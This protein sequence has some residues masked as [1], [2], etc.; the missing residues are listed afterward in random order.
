MSLS[1][2]ACN[3]DSRSYPQKLFRVVRQKKQNSVLRKCNNVSYAF[4]SEFSKQE[5]LKRYEIAEN[6]RFFLTNLV[7]FDKDRFRVPCENNDT[8]LFIGGLIEIKGIRLFCEAVTKAQVKAVV[9]GQ[10][11]LKEELEQKYPN[12]EFVGWKNKAE[13]LPYLKKGR[14]LIFPSICYE[15]MGLTPL[16]VMAYGMPVICSNL[17][18]ASDYVSAD[19]LYDGTDVS[20]LTEKIQ[21]VQAMDIKPVSEEIFCSFEQEKYS[22]E[23]YIQNAINIYEELL[24]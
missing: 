10:G 2:I 1:C 13:M 15:T 6:K 5:L 18:A 17:N 12:I 7:N 22:K 19:F 21:A 9:I 3:C 24:Q 23:T 16:E 4:I 14:C 20:A 11:M 8:F